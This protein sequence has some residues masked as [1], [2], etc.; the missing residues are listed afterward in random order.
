MKY[1]ATLKIGK[2]GLQKIEV[3]ANSLY[4]AREMLYKLYGKPSVLNVS[5][6][7]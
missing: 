7:T 5:L 1:Q 3:D 2:D 6:K 4:H